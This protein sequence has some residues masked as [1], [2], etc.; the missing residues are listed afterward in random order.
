LGFEQNNVLAYTWFEVARQLGHPRSE[1]FRDGL[2]LILK[3]SEIENAQQL[4]TRCQAKQYLG[5]ISI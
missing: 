4:A 3:P 5:C 1:S 2:G